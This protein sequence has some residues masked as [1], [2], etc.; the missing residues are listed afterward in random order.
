MRQILFTVLLALLVPVAAVA[1]DLTVF[2]PGVTTAGLRKLANAWTLETGNRVHIISGT[3]GVI[4]NDVM[5]NTP[6]DVVLLPLLEM[7]DISGKVKPGTN[8]PVGRA[9]F[10]LIAKTGAPHPD[11]STARKFG[12]ALRAAG[13]VGYNDPA[14]QS[15]SGQMVESML[16]RAEFKGIIGKPLKEGAANGVASGAVPY[17]GGVRSEQLGNPAVDLVGMFPTSLNMHIDFSA[18]VLSGTMANDAAASFVRYIA[19]AEA[20]PFWND[21]GILA[22]G[23]KAKN[24]VGP[25]YVPYPTMALSPSN[26]E[27]RA[28]RPARARG[29]SVALAIEGAQTA[30]ATCLGNGYK[31][32]ALIVDSAGVPI[33]MISGDGAAAVT[34][35]IAMGKAQTVLKYKITSGEAAAKANT[36]AAFMAQLSADPLVGPPR[37]GAIPIMVGG[38]MIGAFAVSGAPGGDKDEPCSIAGLAKIQDRLN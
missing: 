32:T 37:Q 10:G 23:F 21:C 36:D 29:I 25:C 9:L 20:A 31:V 27:A 19:R 18:A 12:S 11:I 35:R 16:K 8:V 1:T 13:S 34:Q 6:G 38:Q 5:S 17:A 33:A 3:I 24:E 15:L 30:I 14:T 2:S 4:K 26:D 22:P 28:P 7:K